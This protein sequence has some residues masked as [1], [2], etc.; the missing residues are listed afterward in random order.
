ML[1][2][3]E[4]I[5][6]II[7]DI[8]SS[9]IPID[10]I[11]EEHINFVKRWIASGVEIFRRAKPDIP[12]IHLVSYFMVVDQ[13]SNEFLLVDHKKAQLWL[14]P[15]GHVE[16]NEHPMETVKRE[17]KEELGIEA[18]FLFEDPLFL[19]VTN[20]VGN[21]A[22]HTDVSLWYLL[23]GNRNDHLRFDSNEFHQIRWFSREA[24]PFEQTDPHMKRFI[25]KIIKKLTTLNSYDTSAL[26][27]AKNTADL[28]P[29]DEAQKF[30]NGLPKNAKIIDIGCGPGRDAKIFSNCGLEVLG[31]DFSIKMIESARQNA[32]NC[33]FY[34]MDIE[35]LDFPSETFDGAWISCALLH[36]PKKNIP[37]VLH[38]I[39]AL[40]KPKGFLYLSVKQSHIDE[41]IE[42]DSRY[43]GL[44]KYWS[45][46]EP[47]ELMNLLISA[48]FK[49]VDIIVSNKI[50][51]YN[52]HPLIKIFAKKQ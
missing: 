19:T 51:D 47:D 9:I 21:I 6:L 11:E 4:S 22:P 33:S 40:L 50:I 35:T 13:T 38:K 45:F 31:I 1:P 41:T 5:R 8:V 46:Y 34:V 14:P 2:S 12:N 42:A 49:I 20:T 44:E 39:Y 48:N 29:K 43:G 52:T 10:P 7:D 24:I 25:D 30:V 36:I 32:P 28:H 27:Y 18:K 37:S 15:G 23:K 16:I 3:S 17:V 26:E